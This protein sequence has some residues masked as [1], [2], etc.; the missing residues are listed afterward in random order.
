M[1]SYDIIRAVKSKM[2]L[3]SDNQAAAMIGISRSAVSLH[4]RGLSKTLDAEQCIIAARLLDL[5]EILV[6]ADQQAKSAKSDI[7]REYWEKLAIESSGID[8]AQ[9]RNRTADTRIFNPLHYWINKILP[10]LRK[11]RVTIFVNPVSSGQQL[12]TC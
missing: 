6:I 9:R 7:T 12:I 2:N 10:S 3:P 1:E 11:S 4:K 8:G 5:P